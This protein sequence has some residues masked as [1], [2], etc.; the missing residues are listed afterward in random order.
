MQSA[1]R[2]Y[3]TPSFLPQ[4]YGS[5]NISKVCNGNNSNPKNITL[6]KCCSFFPLI[7]QIPFPLAYMSY[8]LHWQ[9]QGGRSCVV[10]KQRNIVSSHEKKHMPPQTAFKC[11]FW[12][13][14]KMRQMLMHQ[15]A[16]CLK[17]GKLRYCFCFLPV[18]KLFLRVQSDQQP[19]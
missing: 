1:C 2:W 7:V 11:N 14:Y 12:L 17:F 10:E 13:L 16:F 4:N 6:G 9:K 19:V 3:A 18:E 15:V 5:F 8:E